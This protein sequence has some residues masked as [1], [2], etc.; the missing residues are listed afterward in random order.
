MWV[1]NSI[2][3]AISAFVSGASLLTPFNY[4]LSRPIDLKHD[5]RHESRL[6]VIYFFAQLTF[7]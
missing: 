2:F 5:Q 7:L 4:Q 1:C 3:V 6:L